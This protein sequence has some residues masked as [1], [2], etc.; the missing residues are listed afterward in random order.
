MEMPSYHACWIPQLTFNNSIL[1]QRH[2]SLL[3]DDCLYIS[4]LFQK[5]P[6]TCRPEGKSIAPESRHMNE[7]K[8]WQWIIV[9]QWLWRGDL[10][11]N[12]G[13]LSPSSLP[14]TQSSC[15]GSSSRRTI[16]FSAAHMCVTRT[17]NKYLREEGSMRSHCMCPCVMQ[18]LWMTDAQP[19]G[20]KVQ[21][22]VQ[23]DGQATIPVSYTRPQDLRMIE[24]VRS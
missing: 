16:M 24:Q 7:K 5:F 23:K 6:A 21:A 15:V 2:I 3:S 22:M 13:A 14:P 10:N 9:Q 1:D 8:D 4:V 20:P 17:Q 12:Q 18:V 19:M 11:I